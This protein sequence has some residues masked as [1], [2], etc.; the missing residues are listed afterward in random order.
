MITLLQ[1]RLT[2]MHELVALTSDILL[3]ASKQKYMQR[4]SQEQEHGHILE[5]RGKN[6][7]QAIQLRNLQQELETLR[8]LESNEVAHL[9]GEVKLLRDRERSQNARGRNDASV[10]EKSR[11]RS[12]SREVEDNDKMVELR[13]KVK[14]K[15]A[16]LETIRSR[17]TVV[18]ELFEKKPIKQRYSFEVLC[19][20]I[21]DKAKRLFSKY[22]NATKEKKCLKD[23]QVG[24]Y[25]RKISQLEAENLKS[26]EAAN[27]LRKVAVPRMCA[28]VNKP[29][30][31][32]PERE[33]GAAEEVSGYFVRQLVDEVE[34]AFR[35]C[36]QEAL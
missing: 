31:V 7:S 1:E 8:N 35:R 34:T 3:E 30:P 36:R 32:A 15:D 26:S 24:Y 16:Q 4:S 20:F 18:A 5:L 13:Q 23:E 22:E 28:L 2:H 27:L 12:L 10:R 29:V 11:E 21:H 6:E 33:D 17:V 25:H 9:K 14:E 19:D